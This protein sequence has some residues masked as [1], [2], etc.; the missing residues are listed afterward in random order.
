M[1]DVC[2][3][4]EEKGEEKEAATEKAVTKEEFQDEWPVLVPEFAA[5]QER[6]T[7]RSEC[8]GALPACLAEPH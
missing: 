8:S 1:P 4:P 6:V 2:R 3:D 7:D 5:A